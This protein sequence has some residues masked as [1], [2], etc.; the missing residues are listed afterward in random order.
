MK[1]VNRVVYEATSKPPGTIEWERFR[2]PTHPWMKARRGFSCPIMTDPAFQKRSPRNGL[3]IRS[4]SPSAIPSCMSSDHSVS[5]PAW[6][7][8]AT[9]MAS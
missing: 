7:A 2:G 3:T 1:G 5:Q 4:P 6:S 9:I 8:A